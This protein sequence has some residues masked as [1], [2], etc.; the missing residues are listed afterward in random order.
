MRVALAR[1]PRLHEP[2][3]LVGLTGLA[4]TDIEPDKPGVVLAE[5]EEW[6]ATSE[7]PIPAGARVRVVGVEGLRLKVVREEGD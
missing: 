1:R 4:K 2:E 3:R 6:T 7:Q 5:S